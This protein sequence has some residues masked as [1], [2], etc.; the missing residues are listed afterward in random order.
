MLLGLLLLA[1]SAPAF[2]EPCRVALVP[3]AVGAEGSGRFLRVED[4]LREYREYFEARG[5]AVLRVRLPGDSKIEVSALMLREQLERE[6]DGRS[7]FL[8]AHSL[9]GLVA[10]YALK[11]LG[12]PGARALVTIGAPHEGTELARRALRERERGG[13]VAWALRRLGGYDLSALAF[14]E[15]ATPEFVREHAQAFGPVPGVRYLS[16]R[17]ACR[18]C[19]WRLRLVGWW[20]GVPAPS[21]GLVPAARQ[22]FGEDLG[23]YDLDHLSEAGAGESGRAERARFLEAAG[24]SLL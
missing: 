11:S 1:A 21:D 24:K 19:D 8:V 3:G 2:A 13:L 20:G 22:R 17:A 7:G 14:L 10:R 9:G 15:Q 6:W 4:Y 23:E 16:A 18:S 5:C 12:L